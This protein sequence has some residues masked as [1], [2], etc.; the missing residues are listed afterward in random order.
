MFT[1][2]FIYTLF[3]SVIIFLL[4]MVNY[5][6]SLYKKE[7][8]I[9]EQKE[10]NIEDLK[11]LIKKYRLQLQRAISDIDVLTEELAN[12]RNDLKNLRAKNTQQRIE[13]DQLSAKVKELE[14]KIEALI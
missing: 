9:V 8:L 3:V 11:I 14:E 1:Q 4:V 6:K 2:W 7:K 10:Q 13:I 5:T 12:A